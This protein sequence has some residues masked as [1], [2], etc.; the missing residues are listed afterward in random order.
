MY[1]KPPRCCCLNQNLMHVDE[2]WFKP[3]EDLSSKWNW[4]KK[5]T[6]K[7]RLMA[8]FKKLFGS[9]IARF[10]TQRRRFDTKG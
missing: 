7:A 8:L 2:F 6:L 1:A 5:I 4:L 3:L 10:E 9:R